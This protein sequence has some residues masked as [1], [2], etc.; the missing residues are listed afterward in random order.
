MY[1]HLRPRR[2]GRTDAPP[3]LPGASH[4][5]GEEAKELALWRRSGSPA[6]EPSGPVTKLDPLDHLQL[7][8]GPPWTQGAHNGQNV[9]PLGGLISWLLSVSESREAPLPD[10]VY[11][12]VFFFLFWFF[13]Y[14]RSV[15][16][17]FIGFEWR[18]RVF[19]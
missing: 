13:F 15:F 5:Y 14:R 19:Y 11:V 2:M 10:I 1:L 9:R 12:G 18:H 4:L 6:T 3:Y 7:A 17:C 16:A 8:L